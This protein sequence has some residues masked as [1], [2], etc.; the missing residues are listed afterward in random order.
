VT[1]ARDRSWLTRFI[2]APNQM[3]AAGDPVALALRAKYQQVRM[4]NLGL[5]DGDAEGL[6]DYIEAQSRTAGARAPARVT[7]VAASATASPV[8][9]ASSSRPPVPA[10]VM[11]PY[12][13]IQEALSADRLEGVKES[14]AAIAAAAP[15]IASS[16][17]AL[18]ALAGSLQRAADLRAARTAF[19]TLTDLLLGGG[20]TLNT[21]LDDIH[22]AYCPMA[23]KYWLQR[24]VKIQNPYYGKQMLECGRIVSTSSP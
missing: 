4:P 18:V 23:R 17:P 12:L 1:A 6:I 8:E 21:D 15:K 13:R 5:T 9:R 20:Q 7:P 14:A 11:T 16:G 2:V 24:G 10:A 3:N 22:T 19:G